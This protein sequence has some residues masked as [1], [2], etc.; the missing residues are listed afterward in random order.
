MGG[1]FSD[2]ENFELFFK[3]RLE[4]ITL[5]IVF[6]ITSKVKK[7]IKSRRK[8]LVRNVSKTINTF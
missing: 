3:I 1:P 8:K 2:R 4:S 7:Y 6:R 5:G